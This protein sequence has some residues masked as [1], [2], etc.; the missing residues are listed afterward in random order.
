VNGLFVRRASRAVFDKIYADFIGV[1]TSY[2]DLVN[3]RKKM[4]MLVSLAS[5]INAL[6][7]R[8]DDLSERNRHYRD[9]TL[10]GLTFAIREVIA[11]LSV[12]RTYADATKG[13]ISSDR[14]S[15]AA[16]DGAKMRLRTAR[17]S[18]ISS[19][20]LLALEH[21]A[22]SRRGPPIRHRLCNEVPAAH[23]PGDG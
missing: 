3:S 8:L 23:W 17:R 16:V 1:E 21:L 11:C 13:E 12:Y 4:I 6:S 22:D 20:L 10:I 2:R 5:E 18:S 19:A 9:F 15:S 14:K 7:H